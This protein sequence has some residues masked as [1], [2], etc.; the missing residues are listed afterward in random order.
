M[1]TV[2][3][4][5]V[6][7]Q[8]LHKLERKE[9]VLLQKRISKGDNLNS[10]EDNIETV[11]HSDFVDYK[12]LLYCRFDQIECGCTSFNLCKYYKLFFSNSSSIPRFDSFR[13]FFFFFCF[14]FSLKTDCQCSRDFAHSIFYVS[15]NINENDFLNDFT[16]HMRCRESKLTE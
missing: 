6:K 10:F 14:F 1:I 3:I 13:F 2:K 11:E 16:T 5:I 9:N 8:K 7:V 12:C 4:Y 15:S